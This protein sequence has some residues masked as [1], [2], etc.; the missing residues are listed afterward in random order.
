ML[1]CNIDGF[2]IIWTATHPTEGQRRVVGWYRNARVFRKRQEFADWPSEQH[3][4][5]NVKTFR[6][7]AAAQNATLLGVDER[8]IRLGRGPGWMGHAQWWHADEPAPEARDFLTLV[9][10]RINA[11]NTGG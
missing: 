7:R 8:K 4:L 5:D 3:R 6:I 2:D 11:E 1:F 9:A 10:N